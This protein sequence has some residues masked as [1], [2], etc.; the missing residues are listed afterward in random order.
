MN[1]LQLVQE[2]M[3]KSGVRSGLPSTLTGAVDIAA[4]FK[5]W[6]GDSWR[7]LQEES[8]NWFFRQKLDQTLALTASDDE[9]A[10]PSG[11]E[12]LNYRTVTV[13]VTA[14]TD[15]TPVRYVPYEEWR[16]E[17]DT[18]DASEDRPAIITERPDGVLQVW[19]V[20]NQAY[21][22]RY[23]GIY[24]IDTMAVDADTPGSVLTGGTTLPERF[25]WVLVYDA[26]ARYYEH[27]Q[28]AAGLAKSSAKFAAQRARL[29]EKQTP[30]IY[31]KAGVLTG[32]YGHRRRSF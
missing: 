31:V 26:S 28:D 7:E 29:S 3:K 21:T 14:K 11:L 18:I 20:P 12:T 5:M 30:P 19:P 27:H 10:M 22:L 6:V 4:D 8:R 32:A 25:H 24:D 9:Y 17:K 15:E 23:D 13:Y 1:Y 16:M 2:A